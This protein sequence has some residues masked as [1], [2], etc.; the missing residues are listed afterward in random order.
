[1]KLLLEVKLDNL[2]DKI[3]RQILVDENIE[4]IDLC[5]Y[6]IVSMNGTKIPIYEL[7]RGKVI[8]Y[9]FDIKE[10]KLE[11]TMKG[12]HFNELSIRKGFF[13]TIEYNFDYDYSF[14]VEISDICECNDENKDIYFDIVSGS[15]YGLIDNE[16]SWYLKSLLNIKKE[17]VNN[18]RKRE[19]DYL[20][21]EFSVED[22]NNR[23]KE[24]RRVKKSWGLNSYIFNVS[25]RGF[26]KEIKRKILVNSNLTVDS[27]CKGV[28][29]S[30]SGDLS[31]E[32]GMKIKKECVDEFYA[33]CELYYLNLKE[34]Q[35]LTITYD[36]GDNW[37]FDLTL[38]K[39]V[40][41]ISENPF[42]VIKGK[43]YGIVDDCGGPYYL[44]DVFNGS[45]SF[46]EYD[47]NDFDLDE[48]NEEVKKV[49]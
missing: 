35:G 24:Y 47:I 45:S 20:Q 14:Y 12:H 33:D 37:I 31:H 41:G 13:F 25:L 16:Y 4:L 2:N 17:K 29:V 23:I 39:I 1:M 8:Y 48:C 46:G 34:K 49:I 36:F 5:E 38:S 40:D 30:M 19:R 27:F 3:N 28:I 10:T 11:R 43:G 7:H 6:I 15:G 21:K 42:E 22:A 9:P 44:D 18:L 26:S 32:Y